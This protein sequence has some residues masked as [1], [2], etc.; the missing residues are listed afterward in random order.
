MQELPT[1]FEVGT[2]IAL[3]GLLLADLLVV[4]RRPHVP[5][6]KES[7]LWVSFYVALAIAFGVVML[8]IPG[9]GTE[10]ASEFFAGWITEYSLSVDNLFVFV[11]IM[12]RFAVPAED[13]QKVLMVGIL[14]AL[15]LRGIFILLGAAV[16]EQFSWVFYIFGAFLIYTAVK[17]VLDRNEDEEYEDNALIRR[18][19]KILPLTEH[20]DGAKVRT[21]VD[22]KMLFTPMII[23]FFAIGSTDLLFALDSIPAIFGLTEDP[24]IVFTANLFALMG[25]RQLYFLLG[26]LLDRLVYL[27]IGLAVVLGGIGI[28]LVLEALH[29]NELPFLNGG[30]PFPWAP[31]VPIWV[32]LVFIVSVL[33]I[34]T[35]ASLLRSRQ[36]ER[37]DHA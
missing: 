10:P 36:L 30:E 19:R 31:E 34:T 28:K 15:V 16:I 14:I 29:T 22:G 3:V 12:S 7:A 9:G 13:Q 4:G 25:L 11:I 21:V 1:W 2:L 32:S 26:G 8:L 6:T 20:Y 35:V 23:V 17:L 18:M 37:R 5:S 24:F 27:S 33:A